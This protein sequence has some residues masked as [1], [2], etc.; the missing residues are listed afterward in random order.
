MLGMYKDGDV[1]AI[2]PLAQRL[3]SPTPKPGT[4]TWSENGL[5]FTITNK[6]GKLT[7]DEVSKL[8]KTSFAK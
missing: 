4:Q 1:S 7:S 5:R 8:G 3:E 6:V 2:R